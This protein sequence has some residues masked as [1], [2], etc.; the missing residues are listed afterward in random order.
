MLSVRLEGALEGVELGILAEGIGEYIDRLGLS[1]ATDDVGVALGLGTYDDGLPV[2]GCALLEVGLGTGGALPVGYALPL[3][4]HPLV[5]AVGDLAGEV[6]PLQSHV[7]YLDSEVQQ[8]GLHGIPNAV[9]DLLAARLDDLGLVVEANLAA[10]LGRHDVDG[11]GGRARLR[12]ERLHEPERVRDAPT[13]VHV[14]D[15]A[16]LVL[17]EQRVGRG[18]EYQETFVEILDALDERRL[19]VKTWAPDR[20]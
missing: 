1:T 4:L 8:L 16:L 13:S 10:E 19:S 2:D 18:V 15:Q 11:P 12:P 17:G 5:N 20:P 6:G 3:G 9:H 7:D 14:D